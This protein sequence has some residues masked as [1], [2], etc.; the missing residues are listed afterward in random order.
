MVLIATQAVD[1][2][3]PTV[4]RAVPLVARPEP[5]ALASEQAKPAVR[6]LSLNDTSKHLRDAWMTLTFGDHEPHAFVDGVTS[7]LSVALTE[8]DALVVG[9]N[10]V[11]RMIRTIRTGEAILNRRVKVAL[12][13]GGN[14][15]R[16]AQ[17]ISAGFDD[18]FDVERMHPAEAAARIMAIWRRYQMRFE[19]ERVDEQQ[20]TLLARICS[21]HT[22]TRRERRLLLLLLNARDNFASYSSLRRDICTYHEEI[23]VEYLKV[24]VCLVRRKMA[25]GVR[26]VSVPLKGYKLTY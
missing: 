4:L 21:P 17:L 16:R 12:V 10:D 7:H 1:T 24:I 13:A 8:F 14:A 23:S 19:Q 5:S 15:Q 22:L 25:P 20:E 2:E 26:I 11:R 9:G 3:E 18:V 6:Y